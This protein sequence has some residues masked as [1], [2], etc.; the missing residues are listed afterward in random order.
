MK[1][2]S[3]RRSTALP[4][5]FDDADWSPDGLSEADIDALLAETGIGDVADVEDAE[6]RDA[7]PVIPLRTDEESSPAIPTGGEAA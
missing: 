3:L 2:G 5:L 4:D 1:Y 6:A 7:A